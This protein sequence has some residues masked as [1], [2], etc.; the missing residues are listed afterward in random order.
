LNSESNALWIRSMSSS[1]DNE[2]EHPTA[3]FTIHID[4]LTRHH[5]LRPLLIALR[6]NRYI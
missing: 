3:M 2:G 4:W 6:C 5:Q 1:F